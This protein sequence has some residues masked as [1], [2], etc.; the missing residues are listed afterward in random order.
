[1]DEDKTTT[2][3]PAPTPK[4]ILLIEDEHFI[5]E[6]YVRALKNAGYD[7][8]ALIDGQKGLEQALTDAYDIIL[9]DIMVPNITGF[10]ILRELHDAD[11]HKKIH[12]K[13]I[14]TTNLEQTEEN[15]A[16]IEQ[17]ADGYIIKAE[18]TPRQLVDFLTKIKD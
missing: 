10:E 9:L 17:Q 2:P 16:S 8:T 13:I 14:I 7:I 18:V 12:A 3:S 4:K 11:G 5:S 6:L 15:R 1:M